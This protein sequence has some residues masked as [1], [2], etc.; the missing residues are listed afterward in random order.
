MEGRR[1]ARG[2]LVGEMVDV[3]LDFL[4]GETVVVAPDLLIGETVGVPR[5]L[6][7]V[8]GLVQIDFL[9]F[10][11]TAGGIASALGGVRTGE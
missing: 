8:I 5:F 1:V 3:V 2:V 7:G 10:A 4:V 11:G 9:S 6:T